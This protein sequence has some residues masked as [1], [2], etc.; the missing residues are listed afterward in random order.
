VEWLAWRE[1]RACGSFCRAVTQNR[2]LCCVLMCQH[3]VQ[4]TRT[5]TREPSPSPWHRRQIMGGDSAAAANDDKRRPPQQHH[6]AATQNL[7]TMM[8]DKSWKIVRNLLASKRQRHDDD[9]PNVG[10]GSAGGGCWSCHRCT[11]T[12]NDH[13]S[14]SQHSTGGS[15][16]SWVLARS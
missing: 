16:N 8:G 10:K 7:V 4:H 6:V 3:F 15:P 14:C 1:Q 11:A 9:V 2:L 5:H 13:S 12:W